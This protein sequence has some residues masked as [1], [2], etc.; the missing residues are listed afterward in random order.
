MLVAD[1]HAH[2]IRTKTMQPARF[3]GQ[4]FERFGDVLPFRF[5]GFIDRVVRALASNAN[6]YLPSAREFFLQ[7]L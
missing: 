5:T 6:V 2:Q 3:A 7:S 1:R 4:S